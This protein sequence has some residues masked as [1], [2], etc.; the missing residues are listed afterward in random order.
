MTCARA[1]PGKGFKRCCLKSGHYDG[2][3]RDYFFPRVAKR[4]ASKA[5]AKL[6]AVGQFPITA[7]IGSLL[8]ALPPHS[9]EAWDVG[10]FLLSQDSI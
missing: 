3:K 10:F 1:V 9:S 2:S 6:P 8:V 7:L 5:K 4:L